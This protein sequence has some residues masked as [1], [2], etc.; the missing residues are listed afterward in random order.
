MLEKQVELSLKMF[1]S[2][3]LYLV[4]LQ[5]TEKEKEPLEG[6]DWSDMEDAEPLLTF[7]QEDSIQNN[8]TSETKDVSALATEFVMYPPHLYSHNMKDY[9]KYWTKTPKPEHCGPFSSPCEDTSFDS[10]YSSQICDISLDTSVAISSDTSKDK[11]SS[12]EDVRGR[13]RSLGSLPVCEKKHRRRSMEVGPCIPI[14]STPSKS[15]S[16]I[17]NRAGHNLPDHLPKYLEEGFI[18]THC[19]LDMLYSKLAFRG[20]FSKF[21]KSYNTTFPEE[22]EG[23]IA[24]FCNPRTLKDSLWEDLLN[25]DMVWGAFGCHPHFAR[26]YSD[27]NERKLLQA[28]RHPKAIA[29]GEMGLDYSHKCSTEVPTQHK[30][31]GF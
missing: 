16:A 14:F 5:C 20:T 29:F 10:S 11:E 7:S 28:M 3:L 23:C 13:P 9:A 21:R 6:G 4:V 22:F 24:D 30:V 8:N 26:Y 31:K 12:V 2:C 15:D 1:I 18:D 27:L 17:T 19:H 25:E